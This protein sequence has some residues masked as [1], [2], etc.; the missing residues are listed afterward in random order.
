[1]S[2]AE[3]MRQPAKLWHTIVAVLGG[4][5]AVL[6]LL[7]ATAVWLG[8]PTWGPAVAQAQMRLRLD[9]AMTVQARRDTAQDLVSMTIDA[10][11][12]SMTNIAGATLRLVCTLTTPGQQFLAKVQRECQ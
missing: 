12:D 11:M 4:L 9:S 10:R 2:L 1:M 7:W 6:G 5:P 3:R 8:M